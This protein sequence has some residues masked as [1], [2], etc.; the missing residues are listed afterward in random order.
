M[1]YHPTTD[2]DMQATG[3]D[4]L[5]AAIVLRAYDDYRW[6]YRL[7]ITP[8]LPDDND[9]IKARRRHAQYRI[10]ELER[11]FHSQWF[12]TLAL[13]EV[14]PEEIIRKLRRESMRCRRGGGRP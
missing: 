3:Y 8:E 9:A 14:Y 10:G 2:R 12:G 11:F 5:A 1:G 7:S 4:A 13:C 6:F